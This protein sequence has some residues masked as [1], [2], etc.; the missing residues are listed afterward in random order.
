MKDA[1]LIV[2]IFLLVPGCSKDP[3][4]PKPRAYPR[5]EYPSHDS[6]A[7]VNDT[8]PFTFQYPKYAAVEMK[9]EHPCWFDLYM[10]AFNARLHCSY[11]PINN[12]ADFD[13]MVKDVYTIAA[14]INERANFMEDLRIGNSHGVGGL[15]LKF[16]GPA[17]SPLHF[18]IRYDPSFF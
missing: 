2:A 16:T 8:C 3:A 17:A 13:G 6:Q 18:F 1:L 5:V 10:S 11:I 15:A 9:K 14:K 4:S 7:F 12:R